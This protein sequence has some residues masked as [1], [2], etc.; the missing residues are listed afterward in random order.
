MLNGNV[1]VMKSM[2]ADLT[3]ETNVARGF[4][5]IPVAWAVGG[6]V[7]FDILL[8]LF[9]LFLI[10]GPLDPSSVAC[11]RGHRIVGQFSSRILSGANTHI[12]C[13]VSLLPHMLSYHFRWLRFS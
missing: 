2:M 12:S 5:L 8:I 9:V 3:D 4:S 11:Y 1:G 7:G 13:H 6:T 10:S